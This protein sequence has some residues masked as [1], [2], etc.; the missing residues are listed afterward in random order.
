MS[1][2]NINT[3]RNHVID[4]LSRLWNP[5]LAEQPLK[6]ENL[7]NFSPECTFSTAKLCLYSKIQKY[8]DTLRNHNPPSL[9]GFDEVSVFKSVILIFPGPVGAVS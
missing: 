1:F 8:V 7:F 3:L 5:T 2:G 9:A 6:N 4:D